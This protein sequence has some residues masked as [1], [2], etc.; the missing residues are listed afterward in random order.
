MNK[1]YNRILIK[2][3]YLNFLLIL[4]GGLVLTPITLKAQEQ[5]SKKLVFQGIVK[6]NETDETL[7]GVTIHIPKH[8][9]IITDNNGQFSIISASDQCK[10]TLS[11]IGYEDK[12]LTIDL[13]KEQSHPTT[14]YMNPHGRALGEV[15]VNGKSKERQIRESTLPVSVISAKELRGTVSNANEVLAKTVGVTIR[16]S[17]GEGS[18]TRVSVRGLE[19]KRV[20]IFVDA[21]PMNENSDYAD[22]NDFPLDMIERI[23]I[24]KGIVPAWLGGSSV[25]GAVNI[26]LKEY[27][28]HYYDFS[29]DFSSFNT[30]KINA[31][32]KINDAKHGLLFGIGGGY[33]Y[34]D[35]NYKMESPYYKGLVVKRNHDQFKK[36]IGGFSMKAFRW[37]FDEVEIELGGNHNEKQIQGLEYDIKKAHTDTKNYS[38]RLHLDKGDFLLK[39][40]DFKADIMYAFNKTEFIDTAKVRYNFDGT[41]FPTPSPYGGEVAKY[42]SGLINKKQTFLSKI[43]L[44][45]IINEQH[46]FNFNSLISY[47]YGSPKDDVRDASVGYK[48]GFD[49]HLTSM[50][51]GLSYE[52]TT[53]NRRLVNVL[54][55]KHYYYKSS[56]KQ[57]NPFESKVKAQ[58]YDCLKHDFGASESMRY[59]LLSSLYAKGSLAYDVRLP[60]DEELL[61]DGWLIEPST[62]LKPERN[63]SINLGLLYN[64]TNSYG[65][66]LQIELNGF[67]SY[68]SDMIRFVGGPI[69]SHYENF[70]KMKMKGIELEVKA[71]ITRWLYGYGN[72][73]YQDL[74]DDRKH[75]PR[76]ENPNPTKGDRM[77]NIPYWMMNAG[78][79][80]HKEN[81]FGG[82]GHNTRFMTDISYIHK[83]YYDFKQ[84]IYQERIIPTSFTV[85]IGVEHS[86]LHES[87]FL[88]AHINNVADKKILSEFNRPLPGRNMGI[89][90]RYIHK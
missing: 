84:S 41:I 31:V 1:H 10:I 55:G 20:G 26:V 50:N 71:D 76:T 36:L 8:E 60:S 35:N 68:L 22:I 38:S 83:Y 79:E 7:I 88:S 65:N 32:V 29:Y 19:G 33:I 17:G 14:I 45:Y 64:Q 9:S 49:S 66:N 63:K 43:N 75:E 81:L 5:I 80:F 87:L 28:P 2:N 11:Y 82:K 16:S 59:S 13:R 73:T 56:T 44:N 70:G 34:S 58:L 15:V 48:T 42:P 3:R 21:R 86:F 51:H 57:I 18:A 46:S 90:I 4:L 27:P 30:H 24:Y 53:T 72:M 40:L 89:K 47:A 12:E 74:R 85:N 62:K 37:W 23:E 54:A 67:Y 78:L 39:G 6:D 52:F 77:P 25:G 69:R 61:G